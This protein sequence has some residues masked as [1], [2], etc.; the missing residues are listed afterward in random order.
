MILQRLW[1]LSRRIGIVVMTLLILLYIFCFPAAAAPV[2]ADCAAGQ[3][4]YVRTLHTPPTAT[5]DGEIRYVC[6]DC[7]NH[8]TDILFATDHLWSDWIIDKNPDCELPGLRHRVCT[9]GAGH[10]EFSEITAAGHDYSEQITTPPGC[11]SEGVK[12]FSCSRCQDSCTEPIPAAG[13]DYSE[14]ITKEPLCFE[15]GTRTFTCKND[16]SHTYS[17]PIPAPQNHSFGNWAVAVPAQAGVP[18]RE[19][20]TCSSDGF[21]QSREIPA[22]QLEIYSFNQMDI[23]LTGANLAFLGAY[24]VLIGRYARCLMYIEKRRKTLKNLKNLRGKVE[25]FYDFK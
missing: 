25:D 20:R 10:E 24:F 19:E 6:A 18:G 13:H 7:G 23:I 11:E 2:S 22:L 9:R 3:H 14:Q 1:N 15:E 8:Y 21:T 17:E 5:A 4:R 16:S 12:T